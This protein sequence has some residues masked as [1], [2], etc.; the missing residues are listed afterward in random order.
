MVG[1]VSNGNKNEE[2]LFKKWNKIRLLLLLFL[3]I[4]LL[5]LFR[6]PVLMSYILPKSCK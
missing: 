6:N 1:H 4:C 5:L 2:I 3:F